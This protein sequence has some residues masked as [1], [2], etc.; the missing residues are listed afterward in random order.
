MENDSENTPKVVNTEAKEKRPRNRERKRMRV[1]GVSYLR[2][3]IR[4]AVTLVL[5]GGASYITWNV[6]G[7]LCESPL[8]NTQSSL[9]INFEAIKKDVMKFSAYEVVQPHYHRLSDTLKWDWGIKFN[10]PGGVKE[11]EI[12]L[13]GIGD[14]GFDEIRKDE[15][16][17]EY[18][19]F[20]TVISVPRVKLLSLEVQ[21]PDFAED[22]GVFNKVTAD[23]LEKV[24]IE[25]QDAVREKIMTPENIEAAQRSFE[26][27]MKLWFGEEVIV[28]FLDLDSLPKDPENTQDSQGTIT[29]PEELLKQ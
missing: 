14:L 20:T 15:N 12:S 5:I 22:D 6:R 25:S 3:K 10:I 9:Q 28:Q 24:F 13:E 19:N 1:P 17:D 4:T 8:Q 29:P 11:A 18:G 26:D 23:D 7:S 2:R 21:K 27:K 16:I